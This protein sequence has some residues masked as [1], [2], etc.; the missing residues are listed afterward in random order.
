MIRT[1]ASRS[2]KRTGHLACGTSW[3]TEQLSRAVTWFDDG[4]GHGVIDHVIRDQRVSLPSPPA[5]RM[6]DQPKVSLLV[7]NIANS[8]ECVLRAPNGWECALRC[9]TGS[10]ELS[11]P[12]PSQAPGPQEDFREVWRDP[13]CV[14]ADGALRGPSSCAILRCSIVPCSGQDYYT[15][16]PRGFAFIEFV[17]Q[18][19]AEDAKAELDG[20]TLDGRCVASGGLALWHWVGWGRAVEGGPIAARPTCQQC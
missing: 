7:R 18:R 13:R 6:S 14:H 15:K 11:C 8:T 1:V 17:D 16:R 4:R 19:D 3:A 2:R 12:P 5:W 9:N 10:S 20:T